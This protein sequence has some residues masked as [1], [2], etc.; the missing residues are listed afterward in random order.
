MKILATYLKP[1]W[2]ATLLAPI[3]MIIEVAT[4]LIQPLLMVEIVDEG[5]KS[6]NVT[7][8]IRLGV[9][10]VGIALFGIIGGLGNVYFSSIVAQNY[11]TDLRT[12]LF[13]KVQSFSFENLD[14]FKTA[15][16]ITRLTND[17]MQI[18][19]IVLAMLRVLVRAPLLGIG[20]IV[21]ALTLNPGL[22]SILLM[23]IPILALSI[24]FVIKKGIPIFTKVQ[25]KLDRVNTVMRENLTGIRVVKAFVRS[26]YEK[27]RFCEAN[28]DL[29]DITMKASR[30]VGITMPVMMVVMN[31]S[32]VAIIWF[33][34]IK[35]NYGDMQVGQIMAF[36]N[37]MMQVLFSLIML[38]FMLMMV[39]RAK[40]STD[41][42]IEVLKTKTDIHDTLEASDEPIKNGH[43]DFKEVFFRYPNAGGE[44]VL[45]NITFSAI[46]GETVAII[47][48]TGSGKSSLVNLIPR[49]YDVTEGKV[50]IDGKDIR[51]IK[52][53]TL[54][55]CVSMVLQESI[56][57]SGTIMEN[58]RWGR[59]D[60]K[61]E[62]VIEAAKKADAHDFIT[63]FPDGYN[64]V[65]GQR[66]VNLSGGQ[67]QRLAIARALLKNPVILIM[68][69]STSA[70]DMGTEARIQSAL[71]VLLKK[72]TCFIIAQRISTVLEADKI[73]VLEDGEI[74][75]IGN[76]SE[77][78]QKCSIYQ[79]IY[80]SQMGKEVVWHD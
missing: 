40:A 68:D 36:I 3:L 23:T 19:N 45:K 28:N 74:I 9:I 12:D 75:N 22:A 48:A 66:G 1:Y 20:S 31:F 71:K 47:G 24:L 27:Q 72:P 52:L 11:G 62:E 29:R 43:V 80:Y 64:T 56:L 17:V 5:I 30:I 79:D 21:M 39:S 51:N 10:M 59:D 16:L 57:F 60:A 61:D 55:N 6:G 67:K 35:A 50:L 53:N 13:K 41:R 32:I 54:R 33:G 25:K 49:F 26:D 14:K 78:L 77:L 46:S 69:D 15:S 34:G 37:Y 4:N 38:S 58:L 44:P 73:I 76:H 8:I 65:V 2:K 63:H 70:I 42:I 7:Y 18:Q